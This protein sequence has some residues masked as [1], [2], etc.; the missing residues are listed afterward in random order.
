MRARSLLLKFA[1][2]RNGKS[3]RVLV[4]ARSALILNHSRNYPP[5][6]W[7]FFSFV[8][9][10]TRFVWLSAIFAWTVS[11]ERLDRKGRSRDARS[12]QLSKNLRLAPMPRF[13][14]QGTLSITAGALAC[15]RSG[16][17]GEEGTSYAS[18][19]SAQPINQESNCIEVAG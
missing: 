6:E 4:C 17:E 13:W 9:L 2:R 5:P 8:F 3:S 1:R 16:L 14:D 15:E 11:K 12:A 19:V 7:A 18:R 10:C